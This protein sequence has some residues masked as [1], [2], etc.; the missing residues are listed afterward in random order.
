MK[1]IREK[2][3]GIREVQREL[4]W[5]SRYTYRYRWA[6]AWYVLLGAVSTL[7]GLATGLISKR[8]IDVVTGFDTGG[9]RGGIFRKGC[10]GDGLIVQL[11][12]HD[13][14]Y[15]DQLPGSFRGDGQEK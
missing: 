15:G 8:L 10:H 2:L 6:V 13:A 9:F 5:V 12:P 1:R 14:P 3:G 4:R 11:Q 7:A